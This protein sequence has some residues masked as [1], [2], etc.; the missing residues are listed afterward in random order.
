M[1]LVAAE[2]FSFELPVRGSLRGFGPRREGFLLRLEDETG[3]AGFGE[4]SPVGWVGGEDSTEAATALRRVVRAVREGACPSALEGLSIGLPPSARFAVESALL[5]LAARREGRSVSACLGG[6]EVAEVE[7]AALLLGRLPQELETEAAA[8][9][10]AGYRWLKLKIGFR[11]EGEELEGIAAV[12]RAAGPG[13]RLRLDA[14][15]AYDLEAAR[16]LFGRLGPFGIDFVEE[17]LRSADPR[18]LAKLRRSSPVPLALDES[19]R[20][21]AD[22]ERCLEAEAMDAV[23]LKAARLGGLQ[24]ALALG[25]LAA[26]AGLAVVVTDSIESAVGRAGAIQ[27]AAAAGAVD[28]V[29]LGGA[30]ALEDDVVEDPTDRGRPRVRMGGAGLGVVPR[31]G[32]KG[33]LRKERQ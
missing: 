33:C 16:R 11:S 29:G 21:V 14:N 20:S 28:G 15:R 27:L 31:L 9:V 3:Q 2:V 26:A 19:I 17:P 1:K 5:D 4:A 12:R 30:V 13:A 10:G 24:P 32:G 6:P 22:L 25:R 7:V 23:V 8:R 18:E